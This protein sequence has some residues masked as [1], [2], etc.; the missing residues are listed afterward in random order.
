VVSGGGPGTGKAAGQTFVPFNHNKVI[1]HNV[2][3]WFNPYMFSLNA[4][5]TVGDSQRGILRAPG[6]VEWDASLVKDTSIPMLGEG[7]SVQFRAEFFNVANK[8]NLGPPNATVF[9]G[10]PSDTGP[11]SE[12]PNST[13]GQITSTANA[14]RQ[15]QFALKIFFGH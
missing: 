4:L 5:G 9:V 6:L 12:L 1:Q 11:Y 14:S 13:A 8:T 15:I 3:Q 7:G 10:S 2:N